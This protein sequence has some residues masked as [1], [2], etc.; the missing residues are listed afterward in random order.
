MNNKAMLKAGK[1]MPTIGT[2]TDGKYDAVIFRFSNYKYF[3]IRGHNSIILI[4]I[5][6]YK[7]KTL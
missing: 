7:K 4:K 5:Y 2:S 6:L 1:I 3:L